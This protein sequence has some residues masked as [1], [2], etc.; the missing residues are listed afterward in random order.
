MVLGPRHGPGLRLRRRHRGK[1]GRRERRCRASSRQ[2]SLQEAAPP[3]V[4]LVGGTATLTVAWGT[5]TIPAVSHPRHGFSL[6]CEQLLGIVT[7][8]LLAG[9]R[10]WALQ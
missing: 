5:L 8:S 7:A 2:S 1:S 9:A 4:H 10:R 6:L 3:F